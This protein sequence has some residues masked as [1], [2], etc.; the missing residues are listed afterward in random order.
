MRR[1]FQPNTK[2]IN[3]GNLQGKHKLNAFD[4]QGHLAQQMSIYSSHENR[5]LKIG[6]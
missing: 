2:I 1:L 5:V 4:C 6:K 3:Y